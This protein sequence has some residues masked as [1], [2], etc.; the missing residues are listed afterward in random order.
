[1]KADCYCKEQVNKVCSLLQQC[2][3][4]FT[5]KRKRQEKGH[6]QTKIS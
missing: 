4:D 3:Q 2:K 1:M 6:L 5:L